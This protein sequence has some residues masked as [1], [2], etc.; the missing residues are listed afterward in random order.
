MINKNLT[1]KFSTQFFFS[2]YESDVLSLMVDSLSLLGYDLCYRINVAAGALSCIVIV[3]MFYNFV[4][5][6]SLVFILFYSS[7]KHG[8]I[9]RGSFELPT[10]L[11]TAE[12]ENESFNK[13]H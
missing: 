9:M 4:A 7:T 2:L 10:A 13:S 12:A 11:R 1:N 6:R 8:K 3:A 5:D